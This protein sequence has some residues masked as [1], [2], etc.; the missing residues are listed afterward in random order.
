[1]DIAVAAGVDDREWKV[2][3]IPDPGQSSYIH[4]HVY[5]VFAN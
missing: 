4:K 3:I 1:M 5:V 2:Y